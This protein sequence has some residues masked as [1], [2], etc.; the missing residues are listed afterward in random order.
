MNPVG[1]A[2]LLRTSGVFMCD[3]GQIVRG[4]R[5]MDQSPEP[6]SPGPRYKWPLFVLAALLLGIALAVLWMSFAVRRTR[7]L[8]ETN[9]LPSVNGS[10]SR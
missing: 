4:S 8:R 1:S 5:G 3:T 10:D 9:P 6:S 7:E 2:K